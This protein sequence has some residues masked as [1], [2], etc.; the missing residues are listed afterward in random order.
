M[1]K[2][3][4]KDKVHP[5]PPL[6]SDHLAFL[7]ATILTLTVALSPEDREVL[8]YLISCSGSSGNFSGGRRNTQKGGVGGSGGDHPP[9]FHCNCFR[10]YMSFWVRWDSSPNH[11]LIHEIIDAFE[12]GLFQTKNMKNK[13]ERRK[14]SCNGLDDGKSLDE[15][16]ERD[17]LGESESVGVSTD[18]EVGGDEGEEGSE[19][20]SVRWFV[21]ILGEKIWG[22]LDSIKGGKEEKVGRFTIKST[23]KL[24]CVVSP[25]PHTLKPSTSLRILDKAN[26]LQQKILD[27]K[28]CQLCGVVEESTDH[29]RFTVHKQSALGLGLRFQGGMIDLCATIIRSSEFVAEI[30]SA[31]VPCN[32][33]WTK[34]N[35]DGEVSSDGFHI[36]TGLC[37]QDHSGH[38]IALRASIHLSSPVIVVKVYA[39]LQETVLAVEK[40]WSAVVVESNCLEL[41]QSLVHLLILAVVLS[42][43]SPMISK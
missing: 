25:L 11:Q 39:V 16:S 21:S 41:L 18:G 4:R 9:L 15:S 37:V 36:A 33:G 12:D 2:L 26:L 10:C 22:V 43:L 19:K 32:V 28:F 13:K 6:V 34:L 30:Q 1:K 23:Y 42:K 24:L 40:V 20:G 7:P 35:C 38:I 29:A 27:S 3:Y 14:K 5:S 8:A 17:E 31:S